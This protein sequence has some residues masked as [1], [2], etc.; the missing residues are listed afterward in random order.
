[1]N[2]KKIY[3][4]IQFPDRTILEVTFLN[5]TDFYDISLQNRHYTIVGGTRIFQLI[6]SE[7]LMMTKF[8]TLLLMTANYAIS[9]Q[10][11]EHS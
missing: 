3:D 8:T 4:D 11:W 9:R 10:I 7:S 6:L 5:K 1:M 2:Y